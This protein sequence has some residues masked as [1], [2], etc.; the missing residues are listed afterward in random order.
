MV[1]SIIKKL[2]NMKNLLLLLPVLTLFSCSSS[3]V[4]LQIPSQQAVELDYIDYDLYEASIKNDSEAELEVKVLD[5][6]TDEFIRG[7]GL[8]QNKKARVIVGQN[9]KLNLR[10]PGQGEMTVK[11][12]I[13]EEPAI[14]FG[15]QTPSEQIIKFTLQNKSASSIS[16]LIPGVMNPNLSPFS[17]SGVDLKVGQQILF[18]EGGKK[19]VL[20]VVDES[21][22]QNA[23]ID[24]AKLMKDRR[25]ELGL[26]N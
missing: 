1:Y 23:I 5:K 6:R 11:I 7:F 20:L 4:L 24:V 2:K 22:E 21:I 19:Y 16:L 9:G 8:G 26:D 10:N 25:K 18:K 12:D 17:K 14:T 13:S 15:M 3:N